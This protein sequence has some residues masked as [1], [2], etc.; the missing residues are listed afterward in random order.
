MKTRRS[1]LMLVAWAARRR[2]DAW[3]EKGDFR[4]KKRAF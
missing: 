2:E 1:V 4:G 3:G